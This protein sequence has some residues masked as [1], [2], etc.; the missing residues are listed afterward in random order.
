MPLEVTSE[1]GWLHADVGHDNN[2]WLVSDVTKSVV[3]HIMISASLDKT[4]FA[5]HPSY[6]LLMP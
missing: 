3:T 6:T 5:F 2:V 1:G 4:A